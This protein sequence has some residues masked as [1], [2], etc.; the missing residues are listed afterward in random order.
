MSPKRAY[1]GA[2]RFGLD[3]LL[4]LGLFAAVA[5]LAC[6]GDMGAGSAHAADMAWPPVF[7][8]YDAPLP[9]ALQPQRS[10]ELLSATIAVGVAFATAFA[11]NLW[12]I[13]HI[14]R[15]YVAARRAGGKR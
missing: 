4:A 13:R 3:F 7:A 1:P 8:H 14:S 12:F 15:V 11:L 2:S 10:A 9:L 5:L 6:G